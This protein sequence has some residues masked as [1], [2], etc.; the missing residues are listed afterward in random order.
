[1]FI[2]WHLH[3]MNANFDELCHITR[4]NVIILKQ[5]IKNNSSATLLVNTCNKQ[6]VTVIFSITP[7]GTVVSN[8]L[9]W[10]MPMTVV[11]EHNI[12]ILY[13]TSGYEAS[14]R[15]YDTITVSAHAIVY[16][17][18]MYNLR[19][20]VNWTY[21]KFSEPLFGNWKRYGTRKSPCNS[22]SC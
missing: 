8:W 3:S 14:L 11:Y 4:A 22:G 12:L 17:I 16:K 2:K 19:S 6:C 18:Y 21:E 9:T 13:T 1:M 20:I 5:C 10:N 7:V 15:T